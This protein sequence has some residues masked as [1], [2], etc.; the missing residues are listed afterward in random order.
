MRG[1]NQYDLRLI[2]KRIKGMMIV[3]SSILLGRHGEM[4]LKWDVNYLS[5]RDLIK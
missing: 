4:V 2:R 5:Q 1:E 3:E